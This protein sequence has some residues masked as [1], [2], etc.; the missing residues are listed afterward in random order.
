MIMPQPKK[1]V[2][3]ATMLTAQT[4]MTFFIPTSLTCAWNAIRN[5]KVAFT[6]KW[7]SESSV[8]SAMILTAPC[9]RALLL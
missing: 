1:A 9:S 3:T 8:K 5:Q 7:S 6:V 2:I 4:L